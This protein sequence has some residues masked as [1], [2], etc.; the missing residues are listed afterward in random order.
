MDYAR[1]VLIDIARLM[2]SYAPAIAAQRG[3]AVATEP[4]HA[5]GVAVERS[6]VWA[7]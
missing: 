6:G 4:R 2:A 5:T 1:A 7:H 3:S